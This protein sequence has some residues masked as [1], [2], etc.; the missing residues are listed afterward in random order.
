MAIAGACISLQGLFALVTSHVDA[1]GVWDLRAR[2][3]F[4]NLDVSLPCYTFPLLIA[5]IA[6]W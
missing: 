4:L 3:L 1:H 5:G 6:Q 2:H